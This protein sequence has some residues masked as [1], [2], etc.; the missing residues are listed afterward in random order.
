MNPV[1]ERRQ[2]AR[3]SA[4]ATGKISFGAEGLACRVIDVSATGAQVRIDG[5]RASRN[6][7]GKRISLAIDAAADL[8]AESFTGHVVWARPA[9]NGVYLGLAFGARE[10]RPT[11][12]VPPTS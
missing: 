11:P 6:L 2:S 8:A 5:R 10:G 4:E 3:R 7:V 1:D 12:P 9:V